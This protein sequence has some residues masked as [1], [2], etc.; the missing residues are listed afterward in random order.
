ME[1]SEIVNIPHLAADFLR[2]LLDG[3]LMFGTTQPGADHDL[4]DPAGQI[5]NNSL[6][7]AATLIGTLPL[8]HETYP[9]VRAKGLGQAVQVGIGRDKAVQLIVAAPEGIDKYPAFMISYLCIQA[10]GWLIV[11]THPIRHQT[12]TIPAVKLLDHKKIFP[13]FLYVF[14]TFRQCGEKLNR[15]LFVH[16]LHFGLLADSGTM[17]VQC[18]FTEYTFPVKRE[19][20]GVKNMKRVTTGEAT[21]MQ[22]N[23]SEIGTGIAYRNSR[24]CMVG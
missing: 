16:E 18:L 4:I 21:G 14:Y 8:G 22:N 5:K 23:Y 3:Q 12:M 9:A 10:N 20:V 7:T 2:H 13:F 17:E 19:R 15:H 24:M 1:L 6:P 11:E